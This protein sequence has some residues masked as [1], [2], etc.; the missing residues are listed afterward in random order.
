ML[1]IE[2]VFLL[3]ANFYFP[4]NDRKPDLRRARGLRHLAKSYS[5]Y[6]GMDSTMSRWLDTC[7]NL[8][9]PNQIKLGDW[10]LVWRTFHPFF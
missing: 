6:Y 1:M 9:N 5:L 8:F 7:V 3:H 4:I 2:C 10:M